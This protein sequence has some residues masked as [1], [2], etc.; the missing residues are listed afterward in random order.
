VSALLIVTNSVAAE[1]GGT[2]AVMMVPPPPPPKDSA[3]P[4]DVTLV[5]ADASQSISLETQLGALDE[6]LVLAASK[7]ECQQPIAIGVT[8]AVTGN[9]DDA[10]AALH[11]VDPGEATS[12]KQ[13]FR[14]SGP[15]YSLSVIP[16]GRSVLRLVGNGFLRP[17]GYRAWLSIGGSHPHSYLLR[18]SSRVP[19]SGLGL[20]TSEWIQSQSVWPFVQPAPLQTFIP[21]DLPPGER[22]HRS[23][24][25]PAGA[26]ADSQRIEPSSIDV[27]P[28]KATADTKQGVTV[29]V[30]N[31]VPGKYD[32]VLNVEGEKLAFQLTVR[33]YPI[34]LFFGVVLG[35]V[36]SLVVRGAVKYYGSRA[37][38]E[39]DI[40]L[41][42]GAQVRQAF[43]LDGLVAAN[44]LRKAR[45]Y[46]RAFLMDDVAKQLETAKQAG[47]KRDQILVVLAAMKDCPLPGRVRRALNQEIFHLT[48]L[49][50]KTDL[51]GLQR[52]LDAL[53]EE[54][55]AGFRRRFQYW[56]EA[57]R[58]K[59]D[60]ERRD[61]EGRTHA[62]S[63]RERELFEASVG[64]LHQLVEDAGELFLR[65]ENRIGIE[66]EHIALLERIEPTLATLKEWLG[67]P[68]PRD[69]NLLL[70]ILYCNLTAV[71][72]TSK[73]DVTLPSTCAMQLLGSS[74]PNPLKVLALTDQEIELTGI[75]V[76]S[77][78]LLR[79]RW[80][81]IGRR[82]GR[83]LEEV[84]NGGPRL[85]W[86][87]AHQESL[88]FFLP[89]QFLWGQRVTVEVSRANPDDRLVDETNKGWPMEPATFS[90]P[91]QNE[92][93][94]RVVADASRLKRLRIYAF[95]A[96]QGAVIVGT[97]V[98]GLAAAFYWM[99]KPFGGSWSDYINLIAAGIG[100]DVG[101][102]S[103][104]LKGL[105]DKFVS[106]PAEVKS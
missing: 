10:S 31:L 17:A 49:S 37:K 72:T 29:V 71:P 90:F 87:F 55:K 28:Q 45:G 21:T 16:D 1:D 38:N 24:E 25:A 9:A 74:N 26:R 66:S 51:E 3:S 97:C 98:V 11:L 69:E 95:V 2:D 79:F 14:A 76:A 91:I 89:K 73:V 52:D 22:V 106:R 36:I 40:A 100:V 54:A 64:V 47:P 103:N 104:M 5:G 44:A 85:T 35:A 23:L 59:L 13:A 61:L 96:Q 88:P 8:H 7:G 32:G 39:Q 84:V 12:L 82:G 50:S 70:D 77:V 42:E 62:L 102:S 19:K 83:S 67:K 92:Q 105:F 75:P 63:P 78:P 99:D 56:L 34:T 6:P 58:G 93:V 60:A 94:F 41:A 48:R 46:N 68:A 86:L 15:N 53:Q 80:T 101:T 20:Q 33:P 43:V 27:R 65:A 81:V 57:L 18:I 30:S 4:C